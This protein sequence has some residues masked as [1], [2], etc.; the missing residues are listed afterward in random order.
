MNTP[1]MAALHAILR[2]KAGL[3]P[4]QCL[5]ELT[6]DLSRHEAFLRDF[7]DS[8]GRT[9]AAVVGPY[10]AGKTHFLQLSKQEALKRGYAVASLEQ[11]TGLGS[12]SFPHR[13]MQVI[14]R[15]LRAPVPA[16]HV[17][18]YATSLLEAEPNRFLE[19]VRQVAEEKP[20]FSNIHL[21]LQMLLQY[22]PEGLRNMRAAEY[23]SGA[24][25]AGRSGSRNNRASAYQL[26]GFWI[27]FLVTI[28]DCRGLI[29]FIDELE[30]LFSGAMYW[31]IR[32]R[33]TAYRTLAY[34]T[35]LGMRLRMLGAF[36][37]E[38]W[39]NLQEDT[40]DNAGYLT[41]Q[42]SVVPGEDVPT[43]LRGIRSIAPHEL[44][45]LSERNYLSLGEKLKKLHAAARGY[46]TAVN[47]EVKMPYYSG[48]TP[49]IF[50]RSVISA[51]EARWFARE[52]RHV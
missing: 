7:F 8:P 41:I 4:S 51:L 23:L 6:V 1:D 32:S 3:S 28:F 17:M 40:R 37:P 16:G 42:S 10:G 39:Y 21:D 27:E 18:E 35:S 22:G 5:D 46:Q 14:L 45:V 44:A 11:E 24:L 34:Y 15:S 52:D 33:R 26:L 19:Q 29:L 20:E 31:S 13:H 2:L 48:L 43:L 36:T 30:G 9:I 25:Q 47:G 50:S 12:L 38:G 49:R